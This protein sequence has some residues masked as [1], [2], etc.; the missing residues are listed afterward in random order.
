MH[1][2]LTHH[3]HQPLQR[4]STLQLMHNTGSWLISSGQD[5][6]QSVL[7]TLLTSSSS[8][9]S[10]NIC[11]TTTANKNSFYL[12]LVPAAHPSVVAS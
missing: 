7:I 8:S 12:L 4:N 6:K 1:F 3:A 5:W 11:T 9:S 10:S 2:L